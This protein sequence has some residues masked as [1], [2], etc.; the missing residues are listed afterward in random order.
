MLLSFEQDRNRVDKIISVIAI[1][2]I[3]NVINFVK[4]KLRAL[5]NRLLSKIDN[6]IFLI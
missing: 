3:I 6:L 2:Y 5:Q 1:L 4:A